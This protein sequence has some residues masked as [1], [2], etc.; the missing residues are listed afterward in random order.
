MLLTLVRYSLSPFYCIVCFCVRIFM[1]H[2]PLHRMQR[3]FKSEYRKKNECVCVCVWNM[4]L[5]RSFRW[6]AVS[7]LLLLLV[8]LHLYICYVRYNVWYTT[9][10]QNMPMVIRFKLHFSLLT[11][12]LVMNAYYSYDSICVP[13]ILVV[14]YYYLHLCTKD[15]EISSHSL[16]LKSSKRKTNFGI[17]Q[18]F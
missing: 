17:V 4:E 1:E 18:D 9:S 7:F 10:S 13:S 6:F 8:I 2:S 12:L 5:I 14:Y 3:V 11:Y 15:V 16:P